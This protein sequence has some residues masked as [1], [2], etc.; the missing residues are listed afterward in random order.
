MLIQARI[1]RHL[2]QREL[3]EL[4]DL[5][6]QQVQRYEVQKYASASLRR[7]L[8][9]AAALKVDS[10]KVEEL[11]AP[12]LDLFEEKNYPIKEMYRRGWFADFVG[13]LDD[14]SHVANELI[15]EFIT[16][17]HAKPN[18]ALHRKLVRSGAEIDQFAL[19][20]WECRVLQLAIKNETSK[21]YQLDLVTEEWLDKL[22]KL[23]KSDNGPVQA[24]V[25]L[26]QVGITL[27]IEPQLS[28]TYLDG[29][30][31]L[32]DGKSPVIG[33]TLRYDRLD[34]FWF[35]LF[36]ELIH[37]VKHLKPGKIEH[38]FDNFDT[39]MKEEPKEEIE[40]EADS[41]AREALISAEEWANAL[42]RFIQSE[43]AVQKF[44]AKI[45]LSPAIVA[46]RIR[47]E[48]NNYLILR[49]LVGQGEVRKH[50]PEISF[51]V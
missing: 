39:D 32:L 44:A 10:T 28:K 43:S 5:K 12:S 11:K 9:I 51:G 48:S 1:A 27:V 15:E 36:H 21:D 26:E 20:A 23:S 47:Y 2:S 45:G 7:I 34:N 22:R 4:V 46:G 42:P 49:E 41:L 3:A 33:M 19:F 29:A 14:L 16:S 38:I 18:L 50:F 8:E 24:K 40:L 30:A 17:V 25:M 31:L 13:S 35:V 6:E 37:I